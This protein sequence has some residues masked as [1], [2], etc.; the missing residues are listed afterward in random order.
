MQECLLALTLAYGAGLLTGI[1]TRRKARKHKPAGSGDQAADREVKDPA[2]EPSTGGEKP[3]GHRPRALQLTDL[4]RDISAWLAPQRWIEAAVSEL[5][6]ETAGQPPYKIAEIATRHCATLS[7]AWEER[8]AE[9]AFEHG[10]GKSGAR[11]V[12]AVMLRDM[13]FEREAER[14]Q[15]Q[16][17]D[18]GAERH[19]EPSTKDDKSVPPK[20]ES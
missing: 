19:E 11:D 3:R 2:E 14:L 6:E 17:G 13:L 5:D 9:V 12:L 8:L 18:G 1:T 16:K 10:I 20:A 15:Q 4:G 7:E